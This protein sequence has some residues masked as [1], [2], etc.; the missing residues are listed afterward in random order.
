MGFLQWV[1]RKLEEEAAMF[2]RNYHGM[3]YPLGS[4]FRTRTL[5]SA[6]MEV[7]VEWDKDEIQWPL[8]D[9]KGSRWKGLERK[10]CWWY[11]FL[12]KLWP[13]KSDSEPV[14]G[15]DVV[16]RSIPVRLPVVWVGVS[17]EL[18]EFTLGQ[19]Q[20]IPRKC[21]LRSL[22]VTDKH[23][24]RGLRY[25]TASLLWPLVNF[26][27]P[28]LTTPWNYCGVHFKCYCVKEGIRIRRN[29]CLP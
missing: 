18:A 20:S 13:M 12:S 25:V 26:I 21:Y 5:I 15:S 1:S 2:Y 29:A 8:Q 24:V 9:C 6:R 3:G 27:A 4:M 16:S 23:Y 14:G 7:G 17:Q 10:G 19:E 11:L 28:L 22:L